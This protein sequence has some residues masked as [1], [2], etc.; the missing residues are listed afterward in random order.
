MSAALR[1]DQ[2]LSCSYGECG[3]KIMPVGTSVAGETGIHEPEAVEQLGSGAE[4]AA[5]ARHART[6]VERKG[7]RHIQYLVHIRLCRLGHPP[8]GV[9]GEGVKISAGSFGVEYAQGKG[10]LAGAGDAGNAHDLSQGNINIY[11]FQIMD[12]GTADQHFIDHMPFFHNAMELL[13]PAHV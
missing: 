2:F 13:P 1:A 12:P 10:R 6:L 3:R 7:S 4:G 8:S 9:G 11:V 5:D